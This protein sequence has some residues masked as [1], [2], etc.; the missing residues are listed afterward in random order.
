MLRRDHNIILSDIPPGEYQSYLS[1][2]IKA[3]YVNADC[4]HTPAPH[5]AP[6]RFWERQEQLVP[7]TFLSLGTPRIQAA[8]WAAGKKEMPMPYHVHRVGSMFPQYVGSTG[9][10]QA[11]LL[12]MGWRSGQVAMEDLSPPLP[13]DMEKLIATD[14]KCHIRCEK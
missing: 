2:V 10:G 3:S 6:R 8:T 11:I 9:R 1:M 7:A 5:S 14:L 13:L 12:F 4:S